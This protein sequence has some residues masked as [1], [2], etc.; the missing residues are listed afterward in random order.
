MGCVHG[1][2]VHKSPIKY[3]MTKGGPI[4]YMVYMTTM[5]TVE[6]LPVEL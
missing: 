3:F 6:L 1:K 5:T 4:V 2:S